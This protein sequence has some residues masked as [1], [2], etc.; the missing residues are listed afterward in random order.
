MSLLQY[1]AIQSLYLQETET[2]HILTCE[3]RYKAGRYHQRLA[4]VFISKLQNLRHRPII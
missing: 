4:F 3:L 2:T 1:M